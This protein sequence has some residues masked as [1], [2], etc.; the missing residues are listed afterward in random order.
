MI[1]PETSTL[2]TLCLYALAS[3]AGLAGMTMRSP[4][5][6]RMGCW[7]ALA[8]F[9]CQTLMLTLGFHKA[10]PS[11]LSLGAYLQM[12]AWFVLLCGL[13]VWLRLK[14][15]T[16]LLFAAPLALILFAMSAP[17]LSVLVHVPPALKAPFYALHIG[18]LF[19]SLGL[20]TFSFAAGALFLF[21]EGRIKSKQHMKGFWQDMPALSMLDKINAFTTLTAFPLYTLGITAG[22]IWAKPVFGATVTGDPKEV[23][24]IVVWLLFAALFHNRLANGWKGRK[25]A[26]LAVFIFL[27][28]LFSIIVVNTFMETHHAFIRS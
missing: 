17:Y 14:Q 19:L 12:L 22:L 20:L 9:A 6:R 2:T 3:A 21:L 1:S 27:L 10:L 28:C 15:E 11:G 26:Q 23:I 5:W 8:G 18:A 7:L 4:F 13:L 16:A 24:S 25:P